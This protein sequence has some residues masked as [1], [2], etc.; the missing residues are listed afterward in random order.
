M[1]ALDGQVVAIVCR[2]SEADRA[3]AVALAEAG[4]DIAIGTISAAQSE[5][6]STASIANEVWAIG[7]EQFNTVLDASDP[8]AAAAFAAEVADRLGGCHAVIIA[9]GPAGATDFDEFSRDEWDILAAGGLTAPMVAAQAFSRV[10]ERGGGGRIIFVIDAASHGDVPGSVLSEGQ[11][12]MAANMGITW[13]GRG[14]RVISV[15]RDG[16]PEQILRALS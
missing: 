1:A 7:R 15:S 8:T 11:R 2:G 9:P 16:A 10:I 3:I 4:A 12:A 14:V 5:E 6:F 13:A